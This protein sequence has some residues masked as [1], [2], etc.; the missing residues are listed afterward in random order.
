MGCQEFKTS[1]AICLAEFSRN[2]VLF[3]A[4][5]QSARFFQCYEWECSKSQATLQKQGP[6]LSMCF[7]TFSFSKSILIVVWHAHATDKYSVSASS[8]WSGTNSACL[9]NWR[10]IFTCSS[11]KASPCLFLSVLYGRWILVHVYGS[12]HGWF[13]YFSVMLD[14]HV[15]F[16]F[17]CY[18]MDQPGREVLWDDCLLSRLFC[19]FVFIGWGTRSM[20]DTR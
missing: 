3:N 10:Y 15:N 17:L 6:W 18:L 16:R 9:R 20:K 4:G 14:T 1:P 13:W 8:G 11:I 19:I 2:L 5:E 12:I 7:V